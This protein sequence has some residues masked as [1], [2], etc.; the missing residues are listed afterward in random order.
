MPLAYLMHG[1]LSDKAPHHG[2][3]I[4]DLQRVV[5]LVDLD[6]LNVLLLAGGPRSCGRR[7]RADLQDAL[8]LGLDPGPDE[9]HSLD[10]ALGQLAAVLLCCGIT[11]S[12][13]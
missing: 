9:N 6:A 1:W 4:V 5:L 3:P 2:L 7:S 12:S 10:E 13:R 8:Q 11:N